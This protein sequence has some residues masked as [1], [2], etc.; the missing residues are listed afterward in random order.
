MDIADKYGVKVT[1]F[2]DVLCADR[3]KEWNFNAFCLPY[4]N[5]LQYAIANGHDVQLHIHPHWLTTRFD[6]NEFHPSCDF[7]L[8]DFRDDTKFGGIPGIIKRA[9]E[10]LREI[11]MP[12]NEQYQCVA[13]RAGGYNIYPDTELIIKSLYENGIRYDCSMAKGYYFKSGIS[14]VDFRKLPDDPNWIINPQNYRLTLTDQPG[15]LEIPIATIPKTPFEIPTRFKLKKYAHRAVENRGRLIHRDNRTGFIS[16]LKMLF[17]A[18][19]LSFD[20]HTLSIDYLMRIVGYNMDKY[21]NKTDNM[22]FCVVS[23]PKSMGDY[24]FNLMERFIASIQKRYPETEF[25]TCSQ[26]YQENQWV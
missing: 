19:M 21:K 18:R 25:T 12:A 4:K 15:I 11:C 6:G 24:S 20:N 13:F 14:E 10:S 17:S 8:S 7:S 22:M 5:Q 1:L 9:I 16:K 3:L 23:H 2:S 26:L